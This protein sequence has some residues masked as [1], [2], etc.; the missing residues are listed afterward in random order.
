MLINAHDIKKYYLYKN[1]LS[2]HLGTVKNIK[3]QW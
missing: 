3:N 1:Y 2:I